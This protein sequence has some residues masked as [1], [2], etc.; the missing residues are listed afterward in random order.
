MT[1]NIYFRTIKL[2]K[3]DIVLDFI[4]F[5]LQQVYRSNHRPEKK[6]L[7]SYNEHNRDKTLKEE[8][9]QANLQMII[10]D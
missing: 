3:K 1:L 2:N 4:E 6:K 8:R 7:A 9:G 10:D 5:L